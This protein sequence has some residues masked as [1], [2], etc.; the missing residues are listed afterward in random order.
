MKPSRSTLLEVANLKN[1]TSFEGHPFTV[2]GVAYSPDGKT[3]AIAN[4]GYDYKLK[5]IEASGGD[6]INTFEHLHTY[7]RAIAYSPDG[8]YLAMDSEDKD[9][10]LLDPQTG[11]VL[12]TLKGPNDWVSTLA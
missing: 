11:K 9:V 8:K 6:E 3:L 7:S 4:Q 2:N 10:I 1:A 12:I 5:L